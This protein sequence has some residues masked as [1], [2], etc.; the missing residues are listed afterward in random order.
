MHALR[1]ISDAHANRGWGAAFAKRLEC[2]ASA[3]AFVRA[4]RQRIC[5]CLRPRESGAE[6]AA[7]QTL[8][9]L[10]APHSMCRF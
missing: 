6:A 10:R 2:G 1:L 9:D 3:A 8:C 7:V 4:G 5:E